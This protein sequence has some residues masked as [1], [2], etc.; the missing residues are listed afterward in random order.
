MK[1]KPFDAIIVLGA[2]LRRT[3]RRPKT[4][5]RRLVLAFETWQKRA[6][7]HP[8][9]R[10][11]RPQRA[12][13]GRRVYGPLSGGARR[14]C[15]AGH[16]R[17]GKLRHRGKHPQRAG[18]LAP[19]GAL[20]ARFSSRAITTCRAR[21]PFAKWKSCPLWAAQAA[22]PGWP[23]CQRTGAAKCSHGAS[24]CSSIFSG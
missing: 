14:P 16:R 23:I 7:A 3:A 11:K 20:A 13:S 12:G 24:S 2:Q 4:L 21:W 22:A 10:R 15:P 9:L 17:G 1:K 6:R 8:L 5:R 19:N 18:A